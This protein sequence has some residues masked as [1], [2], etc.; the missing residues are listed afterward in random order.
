MT[1]NVTAS[2]TQV[3]PGSKF[4]KVLILQNQNTDTDIFLGWGDGLTPPTVSVSGSTDAGI[5]LARA[6]S[7]TQPTTLILMGEEARAVLAN[8]L[9]A[10]HNA[11]GT[12]TMVVQIH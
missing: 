4:A 3:L 6:Q 11:S 5:M 10:I 12:K 8:P 9:Y 1:V 7:S 2:S